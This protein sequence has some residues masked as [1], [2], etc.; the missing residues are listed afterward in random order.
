M[1]GF[2]AGYLNINM[3]RFNLDDEIAY[4]G[5]FCEAV[6][7]YIVLVYRSRKLERDN[8]KLELSNNQLHELNEYKD[9]FYANLSHDFKTP[10]SI[11][12]GMAEDIISPPNTKRV[13]K[14]NI[15]QLSLFVNQTLEIAHIKASEGSL[16]LEQLDLVHFLENFT[17]NFQS[18]LTKN[19]I[20]LSFHSFDDELVMDIDKS[21]LKRVLANLVNNAIRYTDPYGK[22]KIT[23]QQRLDQNKSYAEIRL[24]DN[25]QGIKEEILPHIFDRYFTTEKS[26]SEGQNLG[27][28]LA[29]VKDFVQLM[30]GNIKVDS[31]VDRGTKFTILIPI[32]K[33]AKSK[34]N[35]IATPDNFKL[36]TLKPRLKSILVIDDSYDF[37]KYLYSILYMEYNIQSAKNALEGLEMVKLEIPD[38]IICDVIMPEM[39]GYQFCEKIRSQEHTEH[40]PII[41]LTAKNQK[42]DK[43]QGLKLGANI[44]LEKPFEKEELLHSVANLLKLKPSPS[45]TK[46]KK[47][48]KDSFLTKL[49]QIIIQNLDNENFDLQALCA[50]IKISRSQL[51]KKVKTLSGLSTSKYIRSIKLGIARDKLLS[52]EAS[53]S[54]IAFAVGFKSNSWFSQAYQETFGESPTETRNHP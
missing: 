47:E 40:I 24:E 12:K 43:I 45:N 37:R 25:G 28:G 7:F 1:M 2:F 5:V 48:V 34:E 15:D 32:S 11:I 13:I 49:D 38:L 9:S 8:I 54:E 4:F 30:K 27:I 42:E 46:S 36:E 41:L 29:I 3:E 10:I 44:F 52:T 21:K 22:I 31:I 51:H 17:E 6:I 35:A 39:N 50:E 19:N 53:I 20:S 23:L 33:T 26:A 18:A 16:Q 14:K